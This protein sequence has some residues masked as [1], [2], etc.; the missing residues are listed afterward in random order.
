MELTGS[1]TL[2]TPQEI[3]K[4]TQNAMILETHESEEFPDQVCYCIGEGYR[5]KCRCTTKTAFSTTTE[6]S[7]Q[8]IVDFIFAK[9]TTLS[10]IS[11]FATEIEGS[12]ESSGI[13]NL[14]LKS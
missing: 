2:L 12:A 10:E 4:T 13:F 6:N 14:H 5:K 3:E 9:T 11:T 7:W 8:A 1:L